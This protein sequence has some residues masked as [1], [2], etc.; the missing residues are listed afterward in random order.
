MNINKTADAIFQLYKREMSEI[1]RR[2]YAGEINDDEFVEQ[3]HK[4]IDDYEYI[5]A[6]MDTL[7][8]LHAI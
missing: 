6:F 8:R 7:R 5:R 3:R 2:Y 1:Q 4:C